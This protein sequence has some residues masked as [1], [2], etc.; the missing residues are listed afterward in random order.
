M[1]RKKIK[2]EKVFTNEGQIEGLPSNPRKISEEEMNRLEESIKSLPE[3]TEARDL[4]V[5]EKDGSYITIGGNMRLLVYRKL[6]YKQVP[7]CILPADTSIDKLRKITMLDN[8]SYG[9]NNWQ[10]IKEQWDVEELKSW[11]VELPKF[12]TN[13]NLNLDNFFNEET[14]KPSKKKVIKCPK[15]GEEIEI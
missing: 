4:I 3:M 2:I 9:E 11:G 15:C 1:E 13:E 10:A 8:K 14:K 7:C 5:V 12:M 6:G